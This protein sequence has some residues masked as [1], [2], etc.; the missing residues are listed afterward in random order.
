MLINEQ[1]ICL[2]QDSTDDQLNMNA[3]TDDMIPIITDELNPSL[4]NRIIRVIKDFVLFPTRVRVIASGFTL[5]WLAYCW[6]MITFGL[7]NDHYCPAEPNLS[8]S[9][10]L[11]GVFWVVVCCYVI[12]RLIWTEVMP[13]KQPTC[14][15]KVGNPS[16]ALRWKKEYSFGFDSVVLLLLLTS[17][18]YNMIYLVRLLEKK[19]YLVHAPHRQ[20][21]S[22]STDRRHPIYNRIRSGSMLFKLSI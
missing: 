6:S 19:P 20:W 3:S 11:H 14:S 21:V 4:R 5:V 18:I 15:F 16:V 12:V 8:N 9:I 10:A 17:Y 1:K 7:T 13:D 2:D 22:I